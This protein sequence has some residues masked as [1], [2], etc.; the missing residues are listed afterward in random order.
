MLKALAGTV[1]VLSLAGVQP[2]VAQNAAPLQ[3]D[4]AQTSPTK[5]ENASRDQGADA[6]DKAGPT[7]NRENSASG[8][9]QKQDDNKECTAV[10]APQGDP[11]AP[12]NYVEYGAGG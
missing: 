7:E 9:S 2:A 4:T 5:Q 10:D 11:N 8:D 1:L 6:T 12:Q 3:S